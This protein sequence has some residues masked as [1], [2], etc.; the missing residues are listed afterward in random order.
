M[1][2]IRGLVH[3]GFG[4]SP[5]VT[6]W[7]AVGTV[8]SGFLSPISVPPCVLRA[9]KMGFCPPVF[10]EPR[11]LTY[12]QKSGVLPRV[13][14][15]VGHGDTFNSA[16]GG[17]RLHMKHPAATEFGT[18]RQLYN[19]I[20]E[21]LQ[22]VSGPSRL[23]GLSVC[24]ETPR[25]ERPHCLAAWSRRVARRLHVPRSGGGRGVGRG[26]AHLGAALGRA[27]YRASR[28]VLDR[29]RRQ[30]GP[31]VAPVA[32]SAR[33]LRSPLPDVQR[34]GVPHLPGARRGP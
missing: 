31:G 28:G 29:Q 21:R 1:I 16:G 15:P 5:A 13:I 11:M 19:S 12:P 34:S 26:V 14:P 22:A 7:S 6:S 23:P 20:L 27:A 8:A 30:R 32:G 10:S 18:S 3:G 25:I 9:S 24:H 2:R 33:Y 17:C 4:P